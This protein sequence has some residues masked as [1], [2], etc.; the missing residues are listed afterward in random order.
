MTGAAR[1]LIPLRHDRVASG[2]KVTSHS[3]SWIDG[4]GLIP[5]REPKCASSATGR[6][7]NGRAECNSTETRLAV[8]AEV[9]R[10]FGGPAAAEAVERLVATQ[11][12]FPLSHG[13][14]TIEHW[15]HRPTHR[16]QRCIWMLGRRLCRSFSLPTADDRRPPHLRSSLRH[17]LSTV[18]ST[19]P[20]QCAV[21]SFQGHR[22]RCRLGVRVPGNVP[23]D[24]R[25]ECDRLG[26]R[27]ALGANGSPCRGIESAACRLNP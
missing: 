8:L 21:W 3:G 5:A 10:C 26:R 12:R 13:A 19:T 9:L 25:P 4:H 17:S 11:Q 23:I 7:N 15:S 22:D 16:L 18:M 1:E 24:P 20:T 2:C 27:R 14:L 6:S